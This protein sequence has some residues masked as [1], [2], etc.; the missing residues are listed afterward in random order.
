VYI[1]FSTCS[2]HHAIFFYH[3]RNIWVIQIKKLPIIQTPSFPCCFV[4]LRRKYLFSHFILGHLSVYIPLSMSETKFH[5]HIKKSGKIIV[6]YLLIFTFFDSK[7]KTKGSAPSDSRRGLTS[8]CSESIY[9]CSFSWLHLFL[10]NLNFYL[11]FR[12]LLPIITL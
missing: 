3:A 11:T 4:F 2:A 5:T 8:V 9:A 6:L 7:G 10:N 12:R 1:L